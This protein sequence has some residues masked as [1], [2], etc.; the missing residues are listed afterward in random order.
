MRCISC[1]QEELEAKEL[2]EK[3]RSKGVLNGI[4]LHLLVL[5]YMFLLYRPR[6][7]LLH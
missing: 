4:N 1:V 6:Q 5:M 7:M 3:V 2:Q